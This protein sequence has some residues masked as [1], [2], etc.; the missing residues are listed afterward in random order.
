MTAAS[1]TAP[2]FN[3][4]FGTG[5]TSNEPFCA[6]EIAVVPFGMNTLARRTG[7]FEFAL[8]TLLR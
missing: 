5:A 7:T 2:F 4:F 8:L 1:V 6:S 3:W